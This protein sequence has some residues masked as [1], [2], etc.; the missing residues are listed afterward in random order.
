MALL[1]KVA[2]VVP[3]LTRQLLWN[4]ISPFMAEFQQEEEE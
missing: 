3:T 2:E 4:F 1:K